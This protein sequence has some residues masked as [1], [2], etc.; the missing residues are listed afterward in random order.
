MPMMGIFT[1][2]AASQTS[3]T[4]IG[5]IAGPV[6]PP[7]TLASFGLRVWMSIAI[8]GKL[9]VTASASL[10]ASS[11]A[12]AS[13]AMFGTF[14]LI[15]VMSGSVVAWRHAATTCASNLQSVPNCLTQ[16]GLVN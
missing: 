15:L 13:G 2:F 11:A 3:L 9:F 8:A 6:R 16:C 14:G 7:V 1:A 5:L 12:L 4:A 10:P